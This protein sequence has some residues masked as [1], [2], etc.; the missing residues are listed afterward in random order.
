M[1]RI[2]YWWALVRWWWAEPI[3]V[4]YI[5]ADK[6]H[7]QAWRAAHRRWRERKPKP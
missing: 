6:Y 4:R 5:V 7:S 1:T 2:R 3:I